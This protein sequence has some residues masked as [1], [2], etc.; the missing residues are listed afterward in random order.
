[1]KKTISILAFIA[2][3]C[4][5]NAQQVLPEDTLRPRPEPQDTVRYEEKLPGGALID[6]INTKEKSHQLRPIHPEKKTQPGPA[7]PS[8]SLSPKKKQNE[9]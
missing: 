1:M 8:D 7:I 6:T 3:I 2:L 5:S 9:Y 4:N